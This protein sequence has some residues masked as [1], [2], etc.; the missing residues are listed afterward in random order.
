MNLYFPIRPDISMR[1]ES[2][3]RSFVVFKKTWVYCDEEDESQEAGV[4][5]T[6]TWLL[7]TPAHALTIIMADV[8]QYLDPFW[9]SEFNKRP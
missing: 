6:H 7:I 8:S 5:A 4:E 2:Y 9:K 1:K 3:M